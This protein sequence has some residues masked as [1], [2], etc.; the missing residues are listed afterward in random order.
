MVLGDCGYLR[1]V[2]QVAFRAVDARFRFLGDFATHRARFLAGRHDVAE[3]GSRFTLR[4]GVA[5]VDAF[6]YCVADVV[7]GLAH[8]ICHGIRL[9]GAGEALNVL[10]ACFHVMQPCNICNLPSRKGAPVF[11]IQIAAVMTGISILLTI[12]LAAVTGTILDKT[13][14]QPLAGVRVTTAAGD[15]QVKTRTDAQGR[16][17]LGSLP[18]GIYTLHLSSDD[19]PPQTIRLRVAGKTA[20]LTLRACSTT[21][22]YTC[23]GQNSPGGS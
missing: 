3:F 13:T 4:I 18:D 6:F 22:D 15:H 20:R 1:C 16:F 21:L 12:V 19:V 17:S 9:P 14:G 5:P 8:F 10:R 2:A 11:A 23:G 7:Y